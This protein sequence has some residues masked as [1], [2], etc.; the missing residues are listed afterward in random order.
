MQVFI[1]TFIIFG[2]CITAMS[3]GV[4][5]GKGCIE[6]SCGGMKRLKKFFR[7]GSPC[8]SCAHNEHKN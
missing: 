7:G 8:E 3:I 6:G 1:A 2:L 5:M 4:I